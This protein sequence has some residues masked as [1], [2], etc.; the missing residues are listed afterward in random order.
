MNKELKVAALTFGL[1]IVIL[2]FA[3]PKTKKSN[4]KGFSMPTKANEKDNE[5]ENA[6]IAIKA[7]RAAMNDNQDKASLD[8]LN[9]ELL[10]EYNIRITNKAGLLSASNRSGTEIAKEQN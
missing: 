8:A 3:L 9:R 10:K 6:T 2:Y 5:Y 1:A 7:Y 4:Q